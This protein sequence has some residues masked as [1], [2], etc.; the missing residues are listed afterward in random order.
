MADFI[1]GLFFVVMHILSINVAVE[2]VI[3]VGFVIV[4]RSPFVV[5]TSNIFIYIFVYFYV[6]KILISSN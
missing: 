1:L 5:K 4:G 3:L 6:I 2:C